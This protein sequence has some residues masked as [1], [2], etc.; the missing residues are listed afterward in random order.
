MARDH[1]GSTGTWSS[2][3]R[4]PAP[5][6]RAW[7]RPAAPS[8][9][10]QGFLGGR[11]PAPT[12]CTTRVLPMAVSL[13]T[14]LVTNFMS[15][16]ATVA[17]LGPIT[18]PMAQAAGLHP[19]TVGFATAFASSFAH[20]LIIGTPANALV[21]IMCRDPRTGRQLVTRTDFLKHGLV[22]FVLSFVVLWGWTFLGLLALAGRSRP[23]RR[24]WADGR[25]DP[26][27]DRR[28]RGAVPGRPRGAAGAARF[29]GRDCARRRR[30]AGAVRRRQVRPGP[31]GP[32]DARHGRQ[33]AADRGSRPRTGTW[34]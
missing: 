32:Q 26:A 23:E 25:L 9:W 10:P 27:P 2:S 6:A 12:C 20:M 21:Y 11:C 34:R 19:W 8:T 22:V 14:G 7:P 31:G 15:D 18:V 3:T 28:R 29:R 16:G 5:S 17:A 1:A 13:V 24:R 30:G 33:G 4:G